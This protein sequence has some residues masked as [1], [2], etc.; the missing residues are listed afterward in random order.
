MRGPIGHR[1]RAAD[2]QPLRPEGK[3]GQ[4]HFEGSSGRGADPCRAAGCLRRH[5][6]GLRST[7]S[8][9]GSS[10]PGVPAGLVKGLVSR[11]VRRFGV[12]ASSARPLQPALADASA[13]GNRTPPNL[14]VV[15]I[16]QPNVATS[17]RFF[18]DRRREPCQRWRQLG[19]DEEPHFIRLSDEDR[20]VEILGGVL[21]ARADVLPLQ[22][23]VVSK[24]LIL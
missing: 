6:S 18:A 12:S 15:S 17:Y 8:L 21:E 3:V 5:R 10:E 11:H 13:A 2:A 7:A 9:L 4:R 22:I 1:G 16:S 19:I 14:S 20:M 23:R 24:N